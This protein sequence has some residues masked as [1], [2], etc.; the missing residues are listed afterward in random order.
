MKLIH[1]IF[2]AVTVL[3][4]LFALALAILPSDGK[5]DSPDTDA[6]LKKVTFRQGLIPSPI[7][8]PYVVAQEKGFYEEEGLDVSILPGEGSASTIK[9]VDIGENDFG[10]VF[11]S[12]ALIAKSQGAEIVSLAAAQQ[13]NN[14][15]VYYRIH[16]N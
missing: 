6:E 11:A 4:A 13:Q 16:S 9:L 1:K 7:W 3:I 10:V 12:E 15:T 2:L 8:I 5:D 14:F